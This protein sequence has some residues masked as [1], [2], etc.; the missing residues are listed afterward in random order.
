MEIPN[1]I[2]VIIKDVNQDCIQLKL[3]TEP[4]ISGSIKS[5]VNWMVL[6]PLGNV[7]ISDIQSGITL[8]FLACRYNPNNELIIW[9]IESGETKLNFTNSEGDTVLEYL[10]K[11]E[12]NSPEISSRIKLLMNYH[13]FDLDRQNKYN[14][15]LFDILC[16]S[17]Y[18][19]IVQCILSNGYEP[20]QEKQTKLIEKLNDIITG[21]CD[22]YW[23]TYEVNEDHFS[24]SLEGIINLLE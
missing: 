24:R 20:G 22:D 4:F 2:D 6:N 9:L 8:F 11:S 10:A 1:Q 18:V 21:E 3:D 13:L 14:D 15:S 5:V 23:S 12:F 16:Y 19:D 17:G 7:D